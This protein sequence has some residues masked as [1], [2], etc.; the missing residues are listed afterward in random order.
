MRAAFSFDVFDKTANESLKAG[1]ELKVEANC[2]DITNV[3]EIANIQNT[4]IKR[5]I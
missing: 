1:E 2:I 3:S 5:I 4:M